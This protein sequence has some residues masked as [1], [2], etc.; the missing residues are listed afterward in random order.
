LEE[1]KKAPSDSGR[2]QNSAAVV[3]YRSRFSVIRT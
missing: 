3:W 2:T 1:L